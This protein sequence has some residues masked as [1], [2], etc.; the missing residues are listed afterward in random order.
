MVGGGAWGSSV[1]KHGVAAAAEVEVGPV[2]QQRCFCFERH[3]N[4][5][6][7]VPLGRGGGARIRSVELQKVSHIPT[8]TPVRH[9]PAAHTP[10]AH[11]CLRTPLDAPSAAKRNLRETVGQS[12]RRLGG[13]LGRE[14]NRNPVM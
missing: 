6:D 11:T 7:N 10:A 14:Q 1:D 3:C 2:L 5:V 12:A 4:G 8:H 9:T 13:K